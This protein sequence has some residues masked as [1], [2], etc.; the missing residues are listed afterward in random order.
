MNLQTPNP[1]ISL[2]EAD[3]LTR[4]VHPLPND[5]QQLLEVNSLE[6]EYQKRPAY[7]KN[8]Y[9]RW[10]TQAKREETR[11]KRINQMLD[12]LTS[13]DRYMKMNY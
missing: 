12:E 13:G 10:I 1:Y 11:Q 4:E 2:E 5:I 7:Q 8:D 9:I 6:K 3:K